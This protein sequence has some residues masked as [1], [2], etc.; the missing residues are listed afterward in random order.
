[1]YESRV[2][3]IGM[4]VKCKH[5]G[6]ENKIGTIY[7]INRDR[8]MVEFGKHDFVEFYSDELITMTMP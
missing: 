5:P 2:P 1:M 8:I 6:W 7:A 3:Y 4:Y